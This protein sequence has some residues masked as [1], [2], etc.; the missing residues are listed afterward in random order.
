MFGLPSPSKLIVLVVVVLAVWHGFKWIN[1]LDKARKGDEPRAARRRQHR[2][3]VTPDEEIKGIDTVSCPT[4][5]TY[6][7]ASTGRYCGGSRCKG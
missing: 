7:P 3:Q 4:C 2:E 5:G 1:R 6:F